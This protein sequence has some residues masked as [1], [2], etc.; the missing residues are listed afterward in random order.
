[1][2]IELDM[3][4][5]DSALIREFIQRQEDFNE[6][7]AKNMDKI[8]RGLYGEEEND[9]VGLVARVAEA[10]KR[11]KKHDNIHK[12]IGYGA[13]GFILAIEGIWHGVKEFLMNK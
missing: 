3:N 13:G 4:K 6:G 9:T 2:A 11:L 12:R 8:L 7:H 5:T 1:M 10:E